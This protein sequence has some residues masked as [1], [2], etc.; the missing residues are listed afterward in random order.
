MESWLVPLEEA[1]V[2]YW[3]YHVMTQAEKLI[4]CEIRLQAVQLVITYY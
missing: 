2:C 4:G 3:E 1:C